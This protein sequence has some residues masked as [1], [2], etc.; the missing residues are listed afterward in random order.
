MNTS[1]WI[2]TSGTLSR[3]EFVRQLS[4]ALEEHV[5]RLRSQLFDRAVRAGLANSGD[6]LVGRRV[7]K[8]LKHKYID[9]VY[10][11]SCSIR[12]KKPVP[13]ILLKDKKHPKSP[14]SKWMVRISK[15][16]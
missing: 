10:K 7:G 14:K 11:L 4:L 8:T 6:A 9:D 3:D 12:K 1:T 13:R 16:Y 15:W 2:R 5:E